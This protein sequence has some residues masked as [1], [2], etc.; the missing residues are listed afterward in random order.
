M[1]GYWWRVLLWL[2]KPAIVFK[3]MMHG[4]INNNILLCYA[5][6]KTEKYCYVV[7][8]IITMRGDN[9]LGHCDSFCHCF[10]LFWI[11]V[12]WCCGLSGSEFLPLLYFSLGYC[13]AYHTFV[14][15]DAQQRISIALD[16]KWQD[17]IPLFFSIVF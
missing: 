4:Y 2:P 3:N 6:G 1:I 17:H 9:A 5:W 7:L 16:N 14:S 13:T 11:S 8:Q 15:Y 10:F 12:S